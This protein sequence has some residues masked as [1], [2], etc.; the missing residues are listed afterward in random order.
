MYLDF[1][2]S[3]GAVTK[4]ER[5]ELWDRAWPTLLE[6]GR[7][8]GVHQ[9][10]SEPVQRFIELL[11]AALASGVAHVATAEGNAPPEPGAWGWREIDDDYRPQG[12]RVGWLDG[13]YLYLNSDAALVAAQEVGR[14][15]GE[16]LPIGSRTLRKR[17]SEKD[18]LQS[19]DTV[20]ETYTVRRRLEGRERHV[21]HLLASVLSGVPGPDKPDKAAE[22]RETTDTDGLEEQDAADE[23][24]MDEEDDEWGYRTDVWGDPPKPVKTTV[25]RTRL[26]LRKS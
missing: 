15:L 4:E 26:D 17:M 6:V 22:Y 21:I 5:T 23:P 2:E 14:N 25:K 13:G 8:Q 24:E 1:A 12:K 18:L 19:Q 16:S 20:R 3:I 11:G 10:A 7:A 9:E